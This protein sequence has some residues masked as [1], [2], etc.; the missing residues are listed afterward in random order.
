MFER[1]YNKFL[2]AIDRGSLAPGLQKCLW[3]LWY[4]GLALNWHDR[5][6]T[7]M[8]YG[9]V[10]LDDKEVFPLQPEDEPDRCFIGLY[11]YLAER[12][13][14]A[15]AT[16][17]EVGSGRG[18]GSSYLCR[19][20]APHEVVGVDYSAAAVKLAGRLHAGVPGLRFVEGDAEA[21][22]FSDESFDI[23]I[24]VESSHCYGNMDAFLGEVRRVLRPGGRFGWVDIRGGGMITD[25]EAAFARCGLVLL[26]AEDI[27]DNVALSM[28]A[29]HDRKAALI[30]R[31]WFGKSIA[32]E[33]AATRD[34]TIHRSLKYGSTRYLCKLLQ[35]PTCPQIS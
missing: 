4:Q 24:N 31:M 22:P 27:G 16:L 12:L 32:R 35:K 1:L 13:E 14:P 25:T 5:K 10:P 20:H 17:L 8:N 30:N 3:R 33:F 19:Y 28:D 34:S 15:G 18:G 9:W 11:R 7:F 2:D 21:L 26:H 29:A 23:V 6:W